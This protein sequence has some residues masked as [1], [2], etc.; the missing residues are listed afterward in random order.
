[1]H[2]FHFSVN[3]KAID[4]PFRHVEYE[5]HGHMQFA[6]FPTSRAEARAIMIPA[7]I[8]IVY[9]NIKRLK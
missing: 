2:C 9:I 5:T 7:G 1:M 4:L 6:I 3:F 8:K